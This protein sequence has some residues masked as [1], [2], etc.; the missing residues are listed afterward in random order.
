[1]DGL[2]RLFLKVSL[3]VCVLSLRL[4]LWVTHHKLHVSKLPLLIYIQGL[5][6]MISSRHH[7]N[8]TLHPNV[9]FRDIRFPV[10]HSNNSEFDYSLK[11]GFPIQ[12]ETPRGFKDFYF[13][14]PSDKMFIPPS[15]RVCFVCAPLRA[16]VRRCLFCFLVTLS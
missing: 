15:H 11:F 6:I 2:K 14:K 4:S 8:M 10:L 16:F 13:I 3:F 12:S 9:A 7:T 5:K 1:M